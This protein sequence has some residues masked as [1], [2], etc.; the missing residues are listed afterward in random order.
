MEGCCD[1]SSKQM[2]PTIL[3]KYKVKNR[4][5]K[6]YGNSTSCSFF[7]FFRMIIQK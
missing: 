2:L 6:T 5:Y 1:I 4:Q 7:I 3:L